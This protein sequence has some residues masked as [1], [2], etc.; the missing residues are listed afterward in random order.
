MEFFKEY[1]TEAQMEAQTLTMGQYLSIIPF[2]AGL[3]LLGWVLWKRIPTDKGSEERL[4]RAFKPPK[5]SKDDVK[6]GSA[7]KKKKKK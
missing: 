3:C 7:K 1:Q 4:A 6:K 5:A 2:S